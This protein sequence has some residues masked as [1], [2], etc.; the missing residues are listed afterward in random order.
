M[1]SG[2][3]ALL[4]AEATVTAIVGSAGV[5]ITKAPQGTKLPF[6][7]IDQSDTE[8]FNSL[9]GTGRLR[10]MGFALDCIASTSVGAETLA[11]AVRE[12]IDD[13]T[14]TAGT[15][16]IKAVILNGEA[17]GYDPPNDGSDVGWHIITLD[18]DIFYDRP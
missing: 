17:Q 2:L 9:D 3:V 12:Y 5:Y 15:F 6:V 16:T 10:R 14:G 1:S 8:E 4:K 13:Y 11:D 18:L 7:V